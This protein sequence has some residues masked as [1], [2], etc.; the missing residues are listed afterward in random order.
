MK[1]SGSMF[2]V[3]RHFETLK[4]ERGIHGCS[5]LGRLTDKGRR[6]AGQLARWVKANT[7]IQRVL[8]FPTAQARASAEHMGRLTD[9]KVDG[10][11][12]LDPVPLGVAE[13][14]SQLELERRAPD[15]AAELERFRLRLVDASQVNLP[16]GESWRDLEVRLVSWWDSEGKEALP[17]SLVICSSSIITMLGNLFGG[18]LPSSGAYLNFPA[19]TGGLR[20]WQPTDDSLLPLPMDASLSASQW[21]IVSHGEAR[22]SRGIVR[23]ARFLPAWQILGASAIVVPGYFGNSRGGPYGVY[24]RL[25]RRL[26]MTGIEVLTF[27]FLGTGESDPATRSFLS[28]IA[29]THAVAGSASGRSVFLIGHSIGCA[30]VCEAILR[31]PQY[32]GIALAPMYAAEQLGLGMTSPSAVR[33]LLREGHMM[34]RGVRFDVDYL[35]KA[36]QA[37]K[38]ASHR[39]DLV[40]FGEEDTYAPAASISLRSSVPTMSIEEA[41]HNFANGES[42]SRLIDALDGFLSEQLVGG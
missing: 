22:T 32:S 27:D 37:W 30:I 13:G 6:E 1:N 36:E 9:L 10:P 33:A 17:G 24:T 14:I 42:S 28:D 41:D 34:R 4:N 21:P 25:A 23:F 38:M 20:A 12:G 31:S 18:T 16:G 29:S 15:S 2:G 5:N 19:P 39:L 35:E 7:S 11:L 3:A 8:F 40:V 26:A